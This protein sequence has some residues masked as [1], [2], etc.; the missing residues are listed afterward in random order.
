MNPIE[1]V[2]GITYYDVNNTE[3]AKFNIAVFYDD[4]NNPEIVKD[5]KFKKLLNLLM[6]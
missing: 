6:P 2:D 1:S 4:P 5:T 3:T